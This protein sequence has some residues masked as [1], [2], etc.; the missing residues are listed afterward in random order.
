MIKKSAV[1]TDLF[2]FLFEINGD[3]IRI[4]QIKS[5]LNT[6]LFKSI[7]CNYE[8][9]NFKLVQLKEDYYIE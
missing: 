3:Y 1:K 6:P 4:P 5:I 7:H 9:S 8:K 2:E